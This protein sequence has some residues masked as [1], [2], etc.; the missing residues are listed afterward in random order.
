MEL[1]GSTATNTRINSGFT[2]TDTYRW[3]KN[4]TSCRP[5]SSPDEHP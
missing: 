5:K 4:N 3:I 1:F 2:H